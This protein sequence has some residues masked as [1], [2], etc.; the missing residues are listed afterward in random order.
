[1]DLHVLPILIPPPTSLSTRSL[2]VFPV[3][4]A[5]AL[6]SCVQPGLVIC[7]KMLLCQLNLM[8]PSLQIGSPLHF[9]CNSIYLGWG[10]KFSSI[11]GQFLH[12]SLV[13]IFSFVDNSIYLLV[14][15]PSN[16]C[17]FPAFSASSTTG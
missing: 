3:H 14:I 9:N 2:W 4:Q 17:D 7:F 5:R 12:L 1:M 11:S 13:I 10:T 6:V 16:I 15:F 8:F